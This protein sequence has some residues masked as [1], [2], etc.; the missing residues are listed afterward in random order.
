MDHTNLDDLEDIDSIAALTEL[1]CFLNQDR[2]G[3]M[4][5]N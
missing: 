1:L 2:D 4:L 3:T 5:S